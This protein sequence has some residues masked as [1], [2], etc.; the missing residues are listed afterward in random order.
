MAVPRGMS[1]SGGVAMCP[2]GERELQFFGAGIMAEEMTVREYRYAAAI[3]VQA[4]KS[5]WLD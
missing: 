3:V 5:T 4:K 1:P 2:T